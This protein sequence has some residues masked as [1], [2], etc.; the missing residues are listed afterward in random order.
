MRR[1]E[2]RA[3][4]RAS[5]ATARASRN[6]D[7]AAGGAQLRGRPRLRARITA[8]DE[9]GSGERVTFTAANVDGVV[10]IVRSWVERFAAGP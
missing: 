2:R 4:R 6:G 9:L 3:E 8:E 1:C 7:V 5:R 10:E